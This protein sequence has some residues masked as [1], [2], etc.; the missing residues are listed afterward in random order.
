MM[1]E[2]RLPSSSGG[3]I[4][5]PR[6]PTGGPGPRDG[7]RISGFGDFSRMTSIL[8]AKSVSSGALISGT[9]GT[10]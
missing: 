4:R 6:L 5:D 10:G 7:F 3:G 2:G 8:G 9:F 1:S